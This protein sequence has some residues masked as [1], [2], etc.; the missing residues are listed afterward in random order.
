[1]LSIWAR[2]ISTE[3][4]I[5]YLFGFIPLGQFSHVFLRSC[6][7]FNFESETKCVINST[8]KIQTSIYFFRNLKKQNINEISWS[9]ECVNLLPEIPFLTVTTKCS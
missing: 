9:Y 5:P 6:G 1:V 3:Y 2:I 8:K 4:I 7:E